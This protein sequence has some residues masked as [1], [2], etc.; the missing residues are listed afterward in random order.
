MAYV[1]KDLD[2]EEDKQAGASTSTGNAPSSS[3]STAPKQGVASVAAPQQSAQQKRGTG[4]TN[5]SEWLNA[6]Q[7][8]DKAISS[9]GSAALGAEKNK[10]GTA[11]DT[12]ETS[13]A[14]NKVINL[15]GTASEALDREAGI[16]PQANR[17]TLLAAPAAPAALPVPSIPTQPRGIAGAL[18]PRT[19]G[20]LDLATALRNPPAAPNMAIDAGL[21]PSTTTSGPIPTSPVET[22]PS[23]DAVLNQHYT[24]PA[25]IDY[26]AGNDFQNATMLGNTSTVSDVLGKDAIA[27]GQYSGGM[28]ALDNI[29]FGADAASQ[30][31]IGAN[32]TGAETFKNDASAAGADFETRAQQ[33][34]D[35]MAAA[36]GKTRTDLT[37]IGDDAKTSLEKRVAAANAAAKTAYDNPGAAG[38]NGS[39]WQGSEA[40]SANAGNVMTASEE[41]RFAALKKYLGYEAPTKDGEYKQGSWVDPNPEQTKSIDDAVKTLGVTSASGGVDPNALKT[42]QEV[43][44]STPIDQRDAL[45]AK[46]RERYPGVENLETWI[47]SWLRDPSMLDGQTSPES[48]AA[49]DAWWENPENRR[50]AFARMTPQQ[51]QAKLA[52]LRERKAKSP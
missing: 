15:Q 34:A 28:R 1:I 36:A 9:T 39:T 19:G 7:G 23:L 27:A 13:L 17:P 52:Q 21:Q 26:Q 2:E 29:L 40:G 8:R 33:R 10:F 49:M 32:K 18:A 20:T 31:A 11:K 44:R 42:I 43:F 38:W 12:A 16:V 47:T 4:F 50:N 48:A 5:L 37:K 24:G 14:G 46:F 3:I 35:D 51:Q 22:G 41:K 45:A 25:G 6:G 30:G